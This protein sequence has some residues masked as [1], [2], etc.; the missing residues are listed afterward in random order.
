MNGSTFVEAD[1]CYFICLHKHA[2][3]LVHGVGL[4]TLEN[5]AY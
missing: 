5:D 4:F 3:V 2:S 1:Q